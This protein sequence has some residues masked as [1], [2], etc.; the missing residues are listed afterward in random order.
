MMHAKR[1]GACL[2]TFTILVSTPRSGVS[3]N[4]PAERQAA[5]RLKEGLALA[6]IGHWDDAR[7]QFQQAYSV[8]PSIDL[9]WNLAL[10]ELNSERPFEAVC[11]FRAYQADARADARK[12]EMSARLIERAA[13]RIGHF[14]FEMP[15]GA[16]ILVDETVPPKASWDGDIL[17]VPPGEHLVRA[18]HEGRRDERRVTASPGA[19]I[20]VSLLL[21]QLAASDVVNAPDGT[22]PVS[23]PAT[24]PRASAGAPTADH[25]SSTPLIAGGIAGGVGVGLGVM[26]VVL[27]NSRATAARDYQH[28][29][30]S[31]ATGG[32]AVCPAPTSD[33]AAI[34]EDLSSANSAKAQFSNWAVG[35]FI[36]GGLAAGTG[37]ALYALLP[38]ARSS[39]KG[40]RAAPLV[41][42]GT[43]GIWVS[44]PW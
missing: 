27:A 41:L 7:L 42:G 11:H 3:Q 32:D 14:R 18:E 8:L 35:S 30:D 9:L 17:D 34:C 37:L 1:L 22:Y 26:F 23:S 28:T 39:G 13:T 24:L 31:T 2:L 36:A 16:S 20:T 5:T 4:T 10:A 33:R 25:R 19:I 15:S 21:Q 6:K 44:M 12:K 40:I 38:P 29:L 43:T